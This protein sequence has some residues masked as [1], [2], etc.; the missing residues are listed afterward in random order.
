MPF[1][2]KKY[3]DSLD[4]DDAQKAVMTAVF[5]KE[6]NVAEMTRGFAA[7]DEASRLMDEGTKAQKEA[8]ALRLAAT[9]D[10]TEAE[11]LRAEAAALVEK[12][13]TWAEQLSKYETDTQATHL[14][15]DALAAEK[16]AY[17]AYLKD[18]IGIEPSLVLGGK[19]PIA[20]PKPREPIV[21]VPDPT[22]PAIDPDMMKGYLKTEEIVPAV[23]LL[24]NLPF[25]LN[26][27]QFKHARLYGKEV[28]DTEMDAIQTAFLNPENRRALGDIAAEHLHFTE[29]EKALAEEA[30]NTRAETMAQEKY[31]ARM[32]A[33]NL[34]GAAVESI[35]PNIESTVHFA[36]KGFSENSRRPSAGM[37]GVS[38]EDMAEFLQVNEQL[39][40]QGIRPE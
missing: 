6:K 29:R 12:D 19:Q 39:N 20:P 17:E 15:R 1:D 5:A 2:T 28:P 38:A 26:K 10:K 25:E 33:L 24:S 40:A 18:T 36:S 22:K 37:A 16:L 4:L 8:E 21:P 32:S 34:P 27:I 7:R 11:R 23:Q 9:A 14:E 3:I 31:E 30:L 35:Q 13:R